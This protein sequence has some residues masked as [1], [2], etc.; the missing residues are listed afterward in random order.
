VT[1]PYLD[2]HEQNKS[3][4]PSYSEPT[5]HH[6]RAVPQQPHVYPIRVQ[7]PAPNYTKSSVRH[8]GRVRGCM[9]L[10]L[11]GVMLIGLMCMGSLA[12]YMLFPPA[13]V[14]ILV[15][16][17]DSRGGEGMA[18]RTDSIMVVG[19]NTAGFDVS[20]L[21]IPRDLFVD[22][23]G[24]GLQRINT[25]NV[26]AEGNQAGTGAQLLS[27]TIQNNFGIGIDKYARLD[28]QAFIAVVDAVGGLDINV[29]YTITDYEFPTADYSIMEVHFDAGMQHMDGERALIY[30]RTRHADDDYRRAERQQQVLSALVRKLANPFN[31]ATAW[32]A[33]NQHVETNLNLLDIIKISPI[34]IFSGGNL[35]QLVVNRDYILPGDGYSVPNYELLQPWISEHFD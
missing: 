31:W 12:L 14:D 26:L 23:P 34:V 2:D 7:Q 24:Y 10:G 5:A 27:Q 33:L 11:I 13:P 35:E 30:A 3:Q 17:L 21:S 4:Q 22:V 16:G 9:F 20:L 15:M 8:I 32:N 19:M 6:V 28:F 1:N 25:V 18:T 29:P